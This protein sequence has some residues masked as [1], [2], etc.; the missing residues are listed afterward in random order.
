MDGSDVVWWFCAEARWVGLGFSGLFSRDKIGCR[1]RS[2]GYLRY[3]VGVMGGGD[4]YIPGDTSPPLENNNSRRIIPADRWNVK[5]L[6]GKGKPQP[7]GCK[8]MGIE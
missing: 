4:G 3:A 1:V 6:R 7:Q 5:T 2:C 8:I